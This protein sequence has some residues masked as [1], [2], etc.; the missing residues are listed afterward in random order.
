MSSTATARLTAGL[1]QE[2]VP[3]AEAWIERFA[4]QHDPAELE[5]D[6]VRLAVVSDFAGT[7]LIR[8]WDEFREQGSLVPADTDTIGRFV[9]DIASSDDDTEV[10]KRRLRMFRNR[11]L[12][13]IIARE[14]DSPGTSDRTLRLWSDFAGAMLEAATAYGA[15]QVEKRFGTIRTRSGDDIAFV[16]LGMGKLGG[17]ELNFSSDVDL[18]YLYDV[19]GESDGR[20]C[21]SA[22]TWFT[23]LSQQIAQLLD[24][25]TADGFVFR[26]DTRLRPF[27]DSGPP[28]TSF[29]SLETYLLNHG[30]TWERYAY[31]KADAVGPAVSPAVH[32]ELF[33]KL[34]RPFVYRRYLDY[35]VFESLREMHAMISAEVE[36]RD[37]ANNLKLGPGGIREVEFIVQSLQLIRGGAEPELATQSLLDVLPQLANARALDA[38]ECDSLR[39]DYL[40]LRRTENFVQAFNDQQT[41]DLPEDALDRARLAFAMGELDWSSLEDKLIAARTRVRQRFDSLAFGAPASGDE[42][43]GYVPL[44][45]G[46]ASID[47]W[48]RALA[49]EGAGDPLVLAERIVAFREDP[50]TGRV[51]AIAESRLDRLVPLLLDAALHADDPDATLERVFRVVGAVL[52]RSAYLSLL[53]ENPDALT[54]LVELCARSQMIADELAAYPVLLDELLDVR[55]F[56]DH[57]TKSDFSNALGERLLHVDD[58]DVEA[59]VETLAQFQRLMM[60][61]ISVADFNNRLPIMKVSDA[62]TFLA[63]AVLD[64]ALGIAWSELVGKHGVPCCDIDGE[65][66]EA[67]FGIVGY[68]KLGGLELSYGSDLDIIFLNDSRGREQ[69]TNGEKPID[70]AVFF[71][72]LARRLIHFLTT[73]TRSGVLYEIDM[74]LRPS[75]R[76][77]LLVSTLEAFARYQEADAWTWEHQALL[78]AR[79]VAGSQRIAEGFARVRENTLRTSVRREALAA[80]VAGMRRKMRAE[81]DRSREDDFDLKHGNGGLVDLEFLVQYLVLRDAASS[82]ELIEFSDNIRQLDALAATG[83]MSSARATELQDIYRAFRQRL[84][85]LAL[86]GRPGL[87]P[88]DSVVDEVSVIRAL[89]Q[90]Y[91]AP[92]E[93][94]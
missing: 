25:I 48:S 17:G 78:R 93:P 75:G 54:R 52:R 20:K 67:G 65:S 59:A 68:G 83:L 24:S 30:R 15:R 38:A 79:P 85:R 92:E 33:D 61:R 4:N 55:V 5:P 82:P 9:A 3:P 14:L 86:D 62:L 37:L 2:L 45:Q 63:E 8:Q 42:E 90:E 72:R 80:D 56:D 10:I 39:D 11:F 13:A 21:V 26:V 89:W 69:Q 12:T 47:A 73:Q 60:F 57:W 76:K 34:I 16:I 91:L 74:R 32:A 28:V 40:L 87:V 1:P 19:D 50:A 31:V 64:A 51:D 49:E 81:L 35:G 44:W 7:T 36:R 6:H 22:E 70:N 41:H 94:A 84:H 53:L 18:I 23:R 58:G 77:G 71:T 88:L 43:S 46:R 27:G 29:A 66:H